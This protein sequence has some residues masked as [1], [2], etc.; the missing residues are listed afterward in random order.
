MLWVA[1]AAATQ[2]PEMELGNSNFN[3]VILGNQNG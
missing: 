2:S 3:P 1:R